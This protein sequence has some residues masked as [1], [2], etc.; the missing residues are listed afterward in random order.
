MFKARGLVVKWCAHA[1][2]GIVVL[3][4][5]SSGH[6]MSA[7]KTPFTAQS[8]LALLSEK[9]VLPRNINL[10]TF[11]P[12]RAEF[13]CAHAA[14]KAPALKPEAQA[15]FEEGMALTSP[16]LWPNERNW[17][18]AMALWSKAAEQGH[19]KA[20]LMWIQTARTGNGV[21]GPK[22][23]FQVQPQDR[24]LVVSRVEYL[25]R[26][27]VA[28]GFYL[29]GVFHEEGYGVKPSVDRAWA[30]WE[31]AADMGSARAQTKIA[32]SLRLGYRDME[33]PNIAEWSNRKVMFQL[34]ECGYAQGYA[35]AAFEL[36]GAIDR[37]T[38]QPDDANIDKEAQFARARQVLHD[39]VKFGSEAAAGY[40]FSAFDGGEPLVGSIKDPTRA[41]RYFTLSKALFNNPDLRFPN[42]DKV[43][44]LP[45]AKL[46][47]WDGQRDSLINAAKGVRETPTQKPSAANALPPAGSERL[48]AKNIE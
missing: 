46:P 5:C 24:E 26:Q 43:L 29:M 16:A 6:A 2:I 12:H 34:L 8:D 31:L 14:T 27:G 20:A 33:K 28:D 19:W 40:L 25:M 38:E 30:F 3:L 36:G 21:N 7:Y 11:D 39:A 4:A 37:A 18:R 41:E 35:Q 44:P 23:Q 22:G 1:A 32:L 13:V 42:L 10:K 47:V 48:Q 17:P 9:G 45:P 15:L